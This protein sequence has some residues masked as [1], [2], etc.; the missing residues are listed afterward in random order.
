[1][2]AVM[3]ILKP[4]V[5]VLTWTFEKKV[6]SSFKHHSTDEYIQKSEMGCGVLPAL[7]KQDVYV[8]R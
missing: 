8:L 2:S 7:E 1:M 6:V 5:S 3:R 4:A